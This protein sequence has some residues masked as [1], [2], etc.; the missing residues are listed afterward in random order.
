M[1]NT[2]LPLVVVLGLCS[3]AGT[4]LSQGV[5]PLYTKETRVVDA[6]LPGK[7]AQLDDK[8][9]PDKLTAVVAQDGTDA[10]YLVTFTAPD[11]SFPI[12]FR[13]VETDI[14]GAKFVDVMREPILTARE[15]RDYAEW[16]LPAHNYGRIETKGDTIKLSFL[17]DK[18]AT[19]DALKAAG[20]AVLPASVLTINGESHTRATTAFPI[21]TSDTAT[22]RA[23][24]KK[25]PASTFGGAITF[26]K[27]P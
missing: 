2:T 24:M 17:E 20:L 25:L 6:A 21:F 27:K 16:A 11:E 14:D 3:T 7:W 23:A 10:S 15:A 4:C 18:A 1:R 26:Q 12:V 5:Y 13:L 22:L 9:K 19:T 8:G